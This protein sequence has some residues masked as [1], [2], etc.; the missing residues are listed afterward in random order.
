MSERHDPLLVSLPDAGQVAGVEIDVSGA[1]REQLGDAKPRR[2][3]ELDEIA[4]VADHRVRRQA[5]HVAKIREIGVNRGGHRRRMQ[6]AV[7]SRPYAAGRSLLLTACCFTATACGPC[8]T[9]RVPPSNV[10]GWP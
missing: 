8:L 7:C 9:V 5:T 4:G 6:Y 3:K 1:K 2:V 10:R